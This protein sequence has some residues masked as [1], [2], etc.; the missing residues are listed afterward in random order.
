[1]IESSACDLIKREGLQEGF[2]EDI[3]KGVRQGKHEG[4]LEGRAQSLKDI[5]EVKFGIEGIKL[6]GRCK[7]IQDLE[8]I[9]QLID[10]VKMAKS[11]DEISRF[12]ESE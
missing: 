12:V 10:V 9:N 8:K 3:L 1:M 6:H 11:V 7:H 5:L 2:Q 4:I